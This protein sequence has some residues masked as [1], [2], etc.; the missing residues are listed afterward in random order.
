MKQTRAFTKYNKD[1]VTVRVRTCPLCN[2]DY[3][4]YEDPVR[5]KVNSLFYVS[6]KTKPWDRINTLIYTK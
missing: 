1:N 4:I 5:S 3:L 6:E 2:R